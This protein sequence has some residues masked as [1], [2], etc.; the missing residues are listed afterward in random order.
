MEHFN[1]GVNVRKLLDEEGRTI[2]DLPLILAYAI[3]T[4]MNSFSKQHGNAS[5]VIYKIKEGNKEKTLRTLDN[6]RG[7]NKEKF[8][9]YHRCYSESSKPTIGDI[10]FRGM[11][12]KSILKKVRLI[13]NETKQKKSHYRS[14]WFFDERVND[15]DVKLYDCVTDPQVKTIV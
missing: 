7:M 9:E 10:N 6:G 8:R 1:G 5:K 11:G 12:S 2:Y 14:E 15:T 13:I 3:E 4:G